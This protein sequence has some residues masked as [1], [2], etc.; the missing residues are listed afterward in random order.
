MSTGGRSGPG[1]R[2]W[3]RK[4]QML[5][6]AGHLLFEGGEVGGNS[7]GVEVVDGGLAF[8]GEEEQLV[9]VE[10]FSWETFLNFKLSKSACLHTPFLRVWGSKLG[11]YLGH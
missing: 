3:T 7:G 5:G 11:H 6:G 8:W 2:E 4:W 1:G 10:T 9:G